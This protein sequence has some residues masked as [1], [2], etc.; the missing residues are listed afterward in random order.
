[1][2]TA[3]NAS[4]NINTPPTMG[5]T[6]GIKGTM[7]SVASGVC[8]GVAS[9]GL[10]GVDM[11]VLSKVAARSFRGKFVADRRWYGFDF[12]KTARWLPT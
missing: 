9:W 8:S 11:S 2:V 4:K 12:T 5:N 3:I 7:A 10:A 1:M 6:M